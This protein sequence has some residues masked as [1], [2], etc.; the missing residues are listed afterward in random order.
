MELNIII[1]IKFPK[2]IRNLNKYRTRAVGFKFF[3]SYIFYSPHLNTQVQSNL[4]ARVEAII[5]T[6][7]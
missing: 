2:A 1:T 6:H 5:V 7:L 4:L 3:L